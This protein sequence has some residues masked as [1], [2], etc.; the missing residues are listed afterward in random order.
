MIKWQFLFISVVILSGFFSEAAPSASKLVK[1]YE[2]A[3][4]SLMKDELKQRKVMGSLYS[5]NK[6]MKKKYFG[7]NLVF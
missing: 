2:K 4:K 1:D 7:S 6:S 5:I 3:K